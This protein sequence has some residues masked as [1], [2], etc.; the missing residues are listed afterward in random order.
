MKVNI[1]R[2]QRSVEARKTN[3]QIYTYIDLRADF[4][5]NGTTCEVRVHTG[6]TLGHPRC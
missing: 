2:G 6:A 4:D 5:P 1:S 3:L